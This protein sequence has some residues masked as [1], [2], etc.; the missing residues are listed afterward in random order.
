[1]SD[2]DITNKYGVSLI[3]GSI[4]IINPPKHKISKEEAL[5]LAAWLVALANDTDTF[6]LIIEQV[7]NS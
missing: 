5:V 2:I 4:L 1:M 7:E 6:G 3:G